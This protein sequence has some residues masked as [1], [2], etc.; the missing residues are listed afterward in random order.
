MQDEEHRIRERAHDIWERE[1]RPVGHEKELLERA[2]HELGLDK[3]R[4]ASG[5]AISVPAGEGDAGPNPGAK[6]VTPIS[7]AQA[8]EE[9]P[10]ASVDPRSERSG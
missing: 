7:D 10:Y 8:Q 4:Q 6:P 9:P 5:P 2:R 1:G 3:T